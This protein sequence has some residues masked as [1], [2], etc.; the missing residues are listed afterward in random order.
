MTNADP[1][2][3]LQQALAGSTEPVKV[4]MVRPAD[5][6]G[7]QPWGR[8]VASLVTDFIG[9]WAV[10]IGLGSAHVSFPVVPALGYW[11]TFW[12]LFAI[13]W[14]ANRFKSSSWAWYRS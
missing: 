11:S 3:L 2:S 1:L 9:S 4:Q 13:E 6:T 5:L 7:K 10:M 14:V 8:L 12:I